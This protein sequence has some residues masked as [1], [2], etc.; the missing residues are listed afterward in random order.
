MKKHGKMP[1][2]LVHSEYDD[3]L[4]QRDN[5]VQSKGQISRKASPCIAV[6]TDVH[7]K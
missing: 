6:Y 2:L 4:M 5:Q 3:Y 7:E 1:Y